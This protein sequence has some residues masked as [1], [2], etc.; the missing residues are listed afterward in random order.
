MPQWKNLKSI[1]KYE[2]FNALVVV[3]VLNGTQQ[4]FRVFFNDSVFNHPIQDEI[5]FVCP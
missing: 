4:T 2:R 1:C 5:H 3:M